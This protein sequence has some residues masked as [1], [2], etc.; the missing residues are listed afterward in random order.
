MPDKVEVKYL[1]NGFSEVYVN[2]KRVGKQE[3]PD[4]TLMTLVISML[5]S[6]KVIDVTMGVKKK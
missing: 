5:T 3:D 2:D 4:K 6:L 1:S